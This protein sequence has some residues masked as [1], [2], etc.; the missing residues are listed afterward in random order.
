MHA[1]KMIMV[2]ISP[3]SVQGYQEQVKPKKVKIQRNR[4]TLTSK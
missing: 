1:R 3:I 2:K 4:Y